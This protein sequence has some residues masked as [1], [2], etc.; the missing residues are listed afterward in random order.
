MRSLIFEVFFPLKPAQMWTQSGQ[1]SSGQGCVIQ[2]GG[3]CFNM[4]SWKILRGN[5][6]DSAADVSPCLHAWNWGW[7]LWSEPKCTAEV[8]SMASQSS[9]QRRNEKPFPS[10]YFP[11]FPCRVTFCD[12]RPGNTADCRLDPS[13]PWHCLQ[14]FGISCGNT[15]SLCQQWQTTK[16]CILPPTEFIFISTLLYHQCRFAT[17]SMLLW[18]QKSQT[19]T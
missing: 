1:S 18:M 9:A 5:I 3:V 7:A 6:I 10:P 15:W 4:W 16:T 14:P 11:R 13:L 2:L 17:C 8:C 12:Q 19:M